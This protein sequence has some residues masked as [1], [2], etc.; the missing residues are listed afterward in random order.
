MLTKSE[1]LQAIDL[2]IAEYTSGHV[3]RFISNHFEDETFHTEGAI[4]TSMD[5]NDAAWIVFR[6]TDSAKNIIMDLLFPQL[7]IPYGNHD[8]KIR[9]HGGFLLGYIGYAR[10]YVQSWLKDHGNIKKIVLIGHSLGSALAT[11]CAVD[12]QYNLSGMDIQCI[13]FGSPRVG[14]VY[15][16]RSYNQRVP[17]TFRYVYKNDFFI[18]IPPKCIEFEHIGNMIQLGKPGCLSF[19]DHDIMRYREA[20]NTEVI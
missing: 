3:S 2:I 7:V 12:I 4:F 18:H 8:S 6:G 17:N 13:T 19:K 5:C 14:N 11:L 16:Q 1:L 10:G 15:F 20:I 9:V